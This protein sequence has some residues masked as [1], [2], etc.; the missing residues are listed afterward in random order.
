MYDASNEPIA[1]TKGYR[2]VHHMSCCWIKMLETLLRINTIDKK[3]FIKIYQ[4]INTPSLVYV[5]HR[6]NKL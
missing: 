6:L 1:C 5:A 4:S 2:T 3:T